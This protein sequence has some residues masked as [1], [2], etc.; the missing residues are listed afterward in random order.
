MSK[1]RMDETRQDKVQ[2]NRGEKEPHTSMPS[3]KKS[4]LKQPEEKSPKN[5]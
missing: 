5:S 4:G 2:N 3:D 1:D